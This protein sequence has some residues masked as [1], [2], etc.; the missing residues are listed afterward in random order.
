MKG[1][2]DRVFYSSIELCQD[3]ESAHAPKSKTVESAQTTEA[4]R[5]EFRR[6]QDGIVRD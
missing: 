2:E 4:T 5:F 1:Y 6:R 3:D